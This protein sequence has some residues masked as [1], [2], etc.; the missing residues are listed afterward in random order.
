[1]N[2]ALGAIIE[3]IEVL[4][5]ATRRADWEWETARQCLQC[6]CRGDAFKEAS[7]WLWPH[8]ALTV[9]ELAP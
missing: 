4:D 9:E 8:P 3:C 7:A 1:M 6:G 2:A 5:G